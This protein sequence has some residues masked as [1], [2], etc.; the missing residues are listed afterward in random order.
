MFMM[1]FRI[2]LGD[3]ISCFGI[4]MYERNRMAQYRHVDEYAGKYFENARLYK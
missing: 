1:I 2:Y 3:E 4:R